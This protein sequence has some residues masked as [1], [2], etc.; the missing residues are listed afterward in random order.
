MGCGCS[1]A[2][3]KGVWT[4]KKGC[5]HLVGFLFHVPGLGLSSGAQRFKGCGSCPQG[6]AGEWG[7]QTG[8]VTGNQ[9]LREKQSLCRAIDRGMKT[10]DA[11]THLSFCP[12]EAHR[13]HISEHSQQHSL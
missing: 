11:A 8:T 5:Q 10:I 9:G 4:E 7:M 12:T 13:R 6:V 2:G 3:Q 1:P